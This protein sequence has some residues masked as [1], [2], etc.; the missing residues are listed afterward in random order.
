[1]LR[2]L[3]LLLVPLALLALPRSEYFATQA[4]WINGNL[5][6]ELLTYLQLTHYP[7]IA[8]LK[9]KKSASNG[10]LQAAGWVAFETWEAGVSTSIADRNGHHYWNSCAESI[11]YAF[12]D[13]ALGDPYALSVALIST[14]PF[15]QALHDPTCFFHGLFELEAACSIGKEWVCHT[16]WTVRT[17]ALAA[18]GIASKGSPFAR[19]AYAVE[20]HLGNHFMQGECIGFYGYGQRHF[21]HLSSNE[22]AFHGYGA[23]A[24]RAIDLL[25]GYRY[26]PFPGDLL[27]LSCIYRP[28]AH[29]CPRH[30]CQAVFSWEWLF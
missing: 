12:L 27:S 17:W 7:S 13:D 21:P 23:I 30:L 20:W 29:N 14:Q 19:A 2:F 15:D 26:A 24:Y 25:I 1:M 11:R 8:G 22:S 16:F 9:E 4:P 10:Y 18:L 3:S 5:Q 28:Y 6:P